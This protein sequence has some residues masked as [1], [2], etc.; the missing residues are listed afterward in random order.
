L[1]G[2]PI[3]VFRLYGKVGGNYS[4]STFRTT[5]TIPDTTITIDG[6]PQTIRGGNQ[7][8]WIK[9]AGWG[10]L[11]GGGMEVWLAPAFGLYGEFSRAA[12]KGQALDDV[13]GLTDERV[14]SV[15]FGARIR[16]GGG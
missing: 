14:T 5:Q 12:L 2:G 1:V 7:V 4:R 11:F 3:G 10:W 15:M 13:E 16:L 9:T 8:Y 6:V